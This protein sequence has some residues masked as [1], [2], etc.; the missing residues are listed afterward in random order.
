MN[1]QEIGDDAK[2]AEGWKRYTRNPVFDA[3]EVRRMVK[4]GVNALTQMQ[5]S[6]GGWGWFSGWGERS[7]P[8]GAT[9][10]RLLLR[11]PETQSFSFAGSDSNSD[12]R[13]EEGTIASSGNASGKLRGP[14]LR[15]CL[16][17][18]L[19]SDK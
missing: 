11:T 18:V 2:R 19:L 16:V 13:T 10:R 4:D 1:A 12:R 17:R 6:D 7:Y 9:R 8:H 3:E 5:C 14:P 15:N